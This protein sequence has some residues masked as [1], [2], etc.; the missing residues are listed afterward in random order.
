MFD[1]GIELYSSKSLEFDIAGKAN[2]S[3]RR[4]FP[5]PK[6]V[7]FSFRANPRIYSWRIVGINWVDVFD[8]PKKRR[9]EIRQKR[10]PSRITAAPFAKKTCV[11]YAPLK[12]SSMF[13]GRTAICSRIYF[14]RFCVCFTGAVL[15]H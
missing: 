13:W 5:I 1:W 4:T 6:G 10:T 15:S 12:E 9:R 14:V 3:A 2:L 11:I 8:W 7:G